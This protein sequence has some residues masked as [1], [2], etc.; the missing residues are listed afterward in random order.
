MQKE[1]H[2]LDMQDGSRKQTPL[3]EAIRLQ[4]HDNINASAAAKD[5][6]F[7]IIKEIAAARPQTLY[8]VNGSS[9]PPCTYARDAVLFFTS[10]KHYMESAVRNLPL[11]RIRTNT[12]SGSDVINGSSNIFFITH[13]L[14][15]EKEPSLDLSDL[16]HSSH[17]SEAF[18][19]GLTKFAKPDGIARDLEFEEILLYEILPELQL[20]PEGAYTT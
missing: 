20:L 15:A 11:L 3:H 19:R 6:A 13:T 14:Y 12:G 8:Q 17:N 4:H 5:Q 9:D 18:A 2:P 7:D 16:N 10:G 1:V